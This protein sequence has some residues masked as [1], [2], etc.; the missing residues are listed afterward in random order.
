[1]NQKAKQNYNLCY[2]KA[3]AVFKGLSAVLMFFATLFAFIYVINTLKAT[4]SA[5]SSNVNVM[6]LGS[7]YFM[8]M[9]LPL[10]VLTGMAI[11]WTVAFIRSTNPANNGRILDSASVSTMTSSMIGAFVCLISTIFSL[12]LIK[13]L[14]TGIKYYES[15]TSRSGGYY[16]G[17]SSN[18]SNIKAA[19]DNM[20][21]L[22]FLLIFMII[23]LILG[24]ISLIIT[25]VVRKVFYSSVEKTFKGEAE[26]CKAAMPFVIMNFVNAVIKLATIVLFILL[27]TMSGGNGSTEYVTTKLDGMMLTSII[28]IMLFLAAGIGGSIIEALLVKKYDSSLKNPYGG[29]AYGTPYGYPN[30]TVTQTQQ[31]NFTG[32]RP[33]QSYPEAA[34]AADTNTAAQNVCPSC[35]TANDGSS[36]FCRTCGAKL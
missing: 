24:T 18:S 12:T 4:G 26:Q 8:L 3:A 10:F 36:I 15:I 7:S 25:S 33:P 29:A 31:N 35:G 17:S 27:L 28:F 34:A 9:A 11:V 14:D 5:A 2:P 6:G 32:Y 30:P 23:I 20:K 19:L 1:M 22:K 21:Y 16:G 13:P